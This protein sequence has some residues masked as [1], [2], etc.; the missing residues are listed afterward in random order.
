MIKITN[1]PPNGENEQLIANRKF[2]E[3][4][5]RITKKHIK[6]SLILQRNQENKNVLIVT[7]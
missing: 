1:Y 4:K 2:T 3:Y 5:I 7:Y 6:R